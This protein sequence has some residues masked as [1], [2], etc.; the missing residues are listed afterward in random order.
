MTAEQIQVNTHSS[1]RIG[2]SKVVY[3]DPFKIGAETHDADVICLTHA[4]FDHFDPE[5]IEKI[6]KEQTI[7]VAPVSMAGELASFAGEDQI[8]LL[9]P[10]MELALDALVIRTVPAYNKVK[11]FHPK[12]SKLL[13]Y[14]L[15]MDG[16]IYYIA[17]DTDAVKDLYD[18]RCDIALVPIGGTY[19]MTAEEAAGLINRIRPKAVIPTHYGSVVGKKEDANAFASAVDGDIEV[20]IRL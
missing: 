9:T 14:L 17:G 18:I 8:H 11:P 3:F 1:I 13:G 12:R 10:G 4:H 5:S 15:E 6:R 7:Y 2:G 20:V 16:T 19:T